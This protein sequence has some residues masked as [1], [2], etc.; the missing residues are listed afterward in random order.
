MLEN[1]QLATYFHIFELLEE[2]EFS[3]TFK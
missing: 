1:I 2:K 3:L